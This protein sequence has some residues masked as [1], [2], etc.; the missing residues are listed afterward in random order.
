MAARWRLCREREKGWRRRPIPFNKPSSS[1]LGGDLVLT[2]P[3]RSPPVCGVQ[4]AS[5]A[6]S[7]LNVSGGSPVHKPGMSDAGQ[8]E[9][10]AAYSWPAD[11]LG[12]LS[13]FGFRAPPTR[14][15]MDL[16]LLPSTHCDPVIERARI[17]PRGVRRLRCDRRFLGIL[18]EGPFLNFLKKS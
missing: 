18:P 5:Y 17:P 12:G 4:C 9:I 16:I 3:G 6:A 10:S 14:R 15:F 11:R 2:W 8:W 1:F 13:L 7:L